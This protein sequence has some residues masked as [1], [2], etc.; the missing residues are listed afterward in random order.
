M[1]LELRYY[2]NKKI[3]REDLSLICIT[4]F[5]SIETPELQWTL[6]RYRENPVFFTFFFHWPEY[7]YDQ[8]ILFSLYL[9]IAS[10]FAFTQNP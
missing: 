5:Y 4:C 8:L 7:I 2:A 3:L 10:K 6:S 1:S 9:L